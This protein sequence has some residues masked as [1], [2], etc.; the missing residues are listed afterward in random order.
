MAGK[1]GWRIPNFAGG[2]RFPVVEDDR[3]F[4][5]RVLAHQLAK[6]MRR[7]QEQRAERWA[8]ELAH[9]A[10]ERVGG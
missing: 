6:A 2:P 7:G 9:A 5:E 1:A 10:R 8:R 3:P 4:R